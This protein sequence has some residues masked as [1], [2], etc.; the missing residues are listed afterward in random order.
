MEIGLAVG[1]VRSGVAL[2]V[3]EAV[4]TLVFLEPERG[5]M[6]EFQRVFTGV[7]TRSLLSSAGAF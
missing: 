7:A 3:D 4:S 6:L 1:G 2:G 5:V